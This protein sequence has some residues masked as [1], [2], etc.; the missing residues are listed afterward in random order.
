MPCEN[1]RLME[2][3]VV[4][5][6]TKSWTTVAC[7]HD[8]CAVHF[9]IPSAPARNAGKFSLRPF[10]CSE[11]MHRF[12]HRRQHE[13]EFCCGSVVP[14]RAIMCAGFLAC[15]EQHGVHLGGRCAEPPAHPVDKQQLSCAAPSG[16]CSGCSSAHP[17][18]PRVVT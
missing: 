2:D 10:V 12:C 9:W 8:I 4:V 15:L 17:R 16:G 5:H 6:A 13:G 14:G 3:P 18:E 1:L 11:E 7:P